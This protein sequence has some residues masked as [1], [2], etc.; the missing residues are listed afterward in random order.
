MQNLTNTLEKVDNHLLNCALSSSIW[1]STFRI[2]PIKLEKIAQPQNFICLPWL[3]FHIEGRAPKDQP[4]KLSWRVP[5]LWFLPYHPAFCGNFLEFCTFPF[6]FVSCALTYRKHFLSLF[7]YITHRG[8]GDIKVESFPWCLC[9]Y[10][11]LR[12]VFVV[13]RETKRRNI[14]FLS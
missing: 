4:T 14:F 2:R 10:K 6:F 13:Y 7:I 9:V 5:K 12:A 11:C 8:R 3:I 1:Y